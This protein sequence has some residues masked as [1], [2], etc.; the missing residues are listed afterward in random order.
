MKTVTTLITVLFFAF[1]TQTRAQGVLGAE[2][3]YSH[4]GANAYSFY[5]TVYSDTIINTVAYDF[6]GGFSDNLAL[7]STQVS[8][9]KYIGTGQF[10]HTFP[11]PGS[12]V[13]NVT[14]PFWTP[15]VTNITNAGSQQLVTGCTLGIGPFFTSNNSVMFNNSQFN[16]SYSFGTY[17]HDMQVVNT[18]ADSLGF[19]LE[20]VI[21]TGYTF[22]SPAG[23]NNAG[24]VYVSASST[25]L[26]ALSVKV[27]EY[28]ESTPGQFV[29]VGS[30]TRTMTIDQAMTGVE[31]NE[32]ETFTISPNPASDFISFPQGSYSVVV[33]DASGQMVLQLQNVNTQ[34]D[35]RSLPA[36]N[37]V[38][39]VLNNATGNYSQHKLIK[40]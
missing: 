39:S 17:T 21:A 16:T 37:Y 29:E 18:D 9:G 23:V 25:G 15:S 24:V 14:T 36:G 31:E 22:P 2:I 34:L 13:C 33:F 27:T 12:Y 7:S 40:Q 4:I 38:V 5:I 6:G 26:Y 20:P 3:T 8:P 30:V 10:S 32:D 28:K 35:V 11:G 19:S 1:L